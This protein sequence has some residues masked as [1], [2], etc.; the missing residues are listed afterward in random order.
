[1]SDS[2][3][4]IL[5]D[6]PQPYRRS[7]E[8]W[9]LSRAF[10]C[11]AL[12]GDVVQFSQP[13]RCILCVV[14][15]P[16]NGER[17]ADRIRIVRKTLRACPIVVLAESIEIDEV[18]RVMRAGVADVIGLP[19]SVEDVTTRASLHATESATESASE[20][21]DK[22]L[23]GHSQAMLKLRCDMAAVA[24]M[25]STVLITGETGVGKGLIARA[26]HR[27]S[28]RRDRPFVHVDCSSLS[29]TVIE[30][31]LFGHERGS[32]TGAVGRHSGRFALAEDGTVFLD[33]IGDLELPLQ[34]KLLRVLQEREYE[35]LGGRE[36][37]YM[38][39]R[40][41]AATN[42]DLHRAVEDGT[43]RADLFFRLNVFNIEVPPLRERLDDIPALVRS[44][45]EGLSERLQVAPPAIAGR[46][47]ETLS[48]HSW[49]G[50]VRE[51]HN[52]LERLVIRHQGGVL[53]EGVLDGFFDVPS[54]PARDT[55]LGGRASPEFLFEADGDGEPGSEEL[56][57]ALDAAG[58]NV[59]RV[60]R[61]LGVPRS[62]LRY[63]IQ[64]LGLEPLI[65]HD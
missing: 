8:D 44:G 51:L 14:G 3:A 25:R 21:H 45:I 54:G 56:S 17:C 5:L 15:I 26:I 39:A 36:T 18:V 41:I 23:V 34:A 29:P 42:R 11:F 48:A 63:R 38:S 22:S 35:R 53:D 31:E 20:A 57:A 64:K 52:V 19:A 16:E 37:L 6:V 55:R 61:R 24:S 40:V 33:E 2:C 59:A 65:P 28:D 43:F 58:G 32:F 12:E 30:S 62:T 27:I 4:V 60:A 1:M 7:F 13:S 9:A 46:F 47:H 50:N 49:P 10:E